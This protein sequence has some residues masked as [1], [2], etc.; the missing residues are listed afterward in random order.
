MA[1]EADPLYLEQL[2]QVSIVEDRGK[3][4]LSPQVVRAANEFLIIGSEEIFRRSGSGLKDLLNKLIDM[5][6]GL[7]PGHEQQ[8][9]MVERNNAA[10]TAQL[11]DS[12][13]SIHG[14]ELKHHPSK[15]DNI[16]AIRAGYM[17][18]NT[19]GSMEAI[20]V[21]DKDGNIERTIE[22]RILFRG[23]TAKGFTMDLKASGGE[24]AGIPLPTGPLTN[25][26]FNIAPVIDTTRRA[27]YTGPEPIA[28]QVDT[29]LYMRD[30]FIK[31]IVN[32]L[33]ILLALCLPVRV[34]HNI[35]AALDGL[36]HKVIEKVTS[37][38][39]I[40][41]IMTAAKEFLGLGDEIITK[42]FTTLFGEA[43]LIAP[44]AP[45][46]MFNQNTVGELT[47]LVGGLR[48]SNIVIES[49]RINVPTLLIEGG[50]PDRLAIQIN[51]RSLRLPTYDYIQDMFSG[52]VRR[53]DPEWGRRTYSSGPTGTTQPTQTAPKQ[54][55]GD[56]WVNANNMG[57]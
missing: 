25:A 42:P 10:M 27:A 46:S 6:A 35:S 41:E 53:E 12:I 24:A 29:F 26:L 44:P 22:K 40:N 4:G 13:A 5:G 54:Q 32:P 8:Q 9:Q 14:D 33:M 45:Y 39:P 15:E 52:L 36:A 7:N 28:Y 17:T 57:K 34:T 11:E 51:L 50:Y 37:W 16:Q 56:N 31:D 48:L 47:A 20:P 43:Y 30:D 23:Y 38:G 2:D 21:Y 49:I 3:F 1:D 55:L 19:S 18:M